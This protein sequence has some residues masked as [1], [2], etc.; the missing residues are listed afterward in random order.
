MSLWIPLVRFLGATP[1]GSA[2]PVFGK[3]LSFYPLSLPLY[4]DAV[5]GLIAI[6]FL[7]MAVWVVRALA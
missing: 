6:S 2:D 3:D 5:S 7:I 4:D 1:A